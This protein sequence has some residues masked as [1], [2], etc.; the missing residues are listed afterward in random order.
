MKS[1]ICS[2]FLKNQNRT[3]SCLY[4]FSEPFTCL[5]CFYLSSFGLCVFDSGA[6]QSGAIQVH[7]FENNISM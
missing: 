7:R 2:S 4:F 5:L 6:E 3:G 1:W